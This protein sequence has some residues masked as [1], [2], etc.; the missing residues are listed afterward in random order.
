MKNSILSLALA[1][2]HIELDI[3]LYM[4]ELQSVSVGRHISVYDQVANPFAKTIY[5]VALASLLSQPLP[6]ISDK[7]AEEY[8]NM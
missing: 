6:Q 1:S 8:T 3:I 2:R 5:K 4:N 7:L